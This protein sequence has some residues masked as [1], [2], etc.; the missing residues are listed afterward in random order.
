MHISGNQWSTD[1]R[2]A[3]L[4]VVRFAILP[5]RFVSLRYRWFAI[6]SC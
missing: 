5:F 3:L 6:V 4:R 1:R 2:S